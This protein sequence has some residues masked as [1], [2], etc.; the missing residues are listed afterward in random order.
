MFINTR[1]YV[2][3]P[4]QEAMKRAT[5]SFESAQAKLAVVQAKV[6]EMERALANLSKSL[7]QAMAEQAAVEE[8]YTQN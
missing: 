6:E 1:V 4:K 2:S 3:V 8:V 5:E 7:D